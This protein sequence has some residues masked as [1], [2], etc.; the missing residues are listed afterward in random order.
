MRC[1]VKLLLKTDLSYN[2]R[3]KLQKYTGIPVGKETRIV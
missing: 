2:F 1:P 3:E